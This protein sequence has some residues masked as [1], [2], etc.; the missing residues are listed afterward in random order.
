MDKLKFER[1]SDVIVETYHYDLVADDDDEAKKVENSVQ[2][3]VHEVDVLDDDD[4]PVNV[5]NH[6]F[7]VSVPFQIKPDDAPFKIAGVVTQFIQM[8]LTDG[9]NPDFSQADLE[10]ISRPLVDHISTVTYQMTSVT[11]DQ[12][13]SLEFSA[14]ADQSNS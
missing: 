13:Y 14:S 1:L 2:V 12:P 6:V 3:G 4:Q 5:K 7:Q 11:L 8:A 9:Q 10:R